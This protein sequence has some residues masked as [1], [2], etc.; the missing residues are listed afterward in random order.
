MASGIG[1][2]EPFFL[3]GGGDFFCDF[4]RDVVCTNLV[5][6]RDN[7]VGFKACVMRSNV[8]NGFIVMRCPFC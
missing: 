8:E 2:L 1:A 4:F 6:L 3:G 7:L 5:R